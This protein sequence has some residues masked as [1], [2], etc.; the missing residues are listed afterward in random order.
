M[1]LPPPVIDLQTCV[2]CYAGNNRTFSNL[3]PLW[4]LINNRRGNFFASRFVTDKHDVKVIRYEGRIQGGENPIII[5][6]Y[7]DLNDIFI[8]IDERPIIMI[9]NEFSGDIRGLVNVV[10][11]FI[12]FDS[13]TYNLRRKISNNVYLV[14]SFNEAAQKLEEFIKGK[15]PVKI[16]EVN[17]KSV[18]IV[19]M[20]F[21][22]RAFSGVIKSVSTLKRL[23]YQYPVCVIGDFSDIDFYNPNYDFTLIQYDGV[24]PFDRS[25][26]KNFQFRA[27][28]IKP[29]LCHL[30]PFTY[31]LYIDADTRF[32]Q[33]I[34]AGFELLQTYDLVVTDEKLTL[35]QLY[36]K[37]LAG[38]EINLLERDQ[39]LKELGKGSNSLRFVNS[40]VIFFKR[41][42]KTLK[43][44][45]DWHTQWL[46]FQEWDE[47][48][49]L[50]RAM[51]KNKSLSIKHLSTDW[52]SPHLTES[53]II[54]HN[55]GRG[56]VRS[57]H[58]NNN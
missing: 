4:E 30:S 15:D 35:E 49:A 8:Y 51:H 3:L 46:R 7:K 22:Q 23:G 45:R 26:A 11:C 47:Q 55:Y 48:L 21:G 56:E 16:I 37:K 34:Q 42:D 12:C 29:Q 20:A 1:I 52:N 14:T 31:N 9:E 10:S 53:S 13:K 43:L 39:T 28:R 36:N 33:P 58:E 50:M 24:S 5:S 17:G 19:Y 18:G 44:F 57:N 54:F 27:G 40:G 38:W 25:K 41:S 6:S 2:D 32:I